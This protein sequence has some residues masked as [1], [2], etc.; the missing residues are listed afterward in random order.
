MTTEATLREGE[1]A[2]YRGGFAI[3]TLEQQRNDAK[4][5]KKR[6]YQPA[7]L[8]L[9]L[10]LPVPFPWLALSSAVLYHRLSGG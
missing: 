5:R 9:A 7:I 8:F 6:T 4:G 2:A 1:A 10:V 3:V